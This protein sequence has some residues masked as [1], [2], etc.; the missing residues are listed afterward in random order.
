MKIDYNSIV[1]T[2]KQ[3]ACYTKTIEL[4]PFIPG[5]DLLP[6]KLY[7]LQILTLLYPSKRKLIGGLAFSQ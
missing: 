4:N 5:N 1:L 6:T 7:K 2:P 3:K